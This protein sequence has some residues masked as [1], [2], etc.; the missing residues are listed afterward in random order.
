MASDEESS[1][2]SSTDSDDG[3]NESFSTTDL[4]DTDTELNHRTSSPPV[5]SSSTLLSQNLSDNSISSPNL[6][7][8]SSTEGSIGSLNSRKRK[9]KT[10][11]DS[12]TI[13]KEHLD[14]IKKTFVI[15][16]DG[17]FCKFVLPNQAV[18]NRKYS[19][20]TCTSSLKYHLLHEHG[21]VFK[22]SDSNKKKIKLDVDQ[23][24]VEWIIDDLQPLKVGEAPKFIEFVNALDPSYKIPCL[25][26]IEYL[27]DNYFE[28]SLQSIKEKIQQI[29]NK[30]HVTTDIWTSSPGDPYISVTLHFIDN[31]NKLKHLL[32]DM[33]HFPGVHDYITISDMLDKIFK[34]YGIKHKIYSITSDN[35]SNMIK[36]FSRLKKK[37]EREGIHVV[38]IRCF[39]HI[40]HLVV[41]QFLKDAYVSK[42]VKKLRS[43]FKKIKRKTLKRTLKALCVVNQEP[44]LCV[45][46]DPDLELNHLSLS[47]DEWNSLSQIKEILEPFKKATLDLSG[48]S[49]TASHLFPIMDHLNKHLKKFFLKRDFASYKP[50][51]EKT[52]AKFNKYWDEI[53]SFALN[54]HILDPRFKLSLIERSKKSSC[55]IFLKRMLNEIDEQNN[56]NLEQINNNNSDSN[57][58]PYSLIET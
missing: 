53:E 23:K 18:C 4:S 16:G 58:K 35:A 46:L 19:V 5:Q 29:K 9:S 12:D 32:L 27:I 15:E 26:K 28:K 49:L 17:T 8:T 34:D 43:L 56:T 3:S 41:S 10:N 24:L 38:H 48:D 1:S 55:K 25:S 14:V 57:K 44:E 45:K 11:E 36:A 20:N 21:F 40:L 51:F 2:Y 13:V 31:Q 52:I 7:S 33:R 30:F 6:P 54:A 37:Y 47:D 22:N 39:A 42:T 50:A